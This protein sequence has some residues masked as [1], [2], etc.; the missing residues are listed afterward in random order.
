MA[1]KILGGI[2]IALSS[3]LLVAS[4]VGIAAAWYY[5]EPLTEE[6]VARLDK[7]NNELAQA[8]TAL[9]DAQGEL[10]RALRIVDSSEE[11]FENFGEQIAVAKGFLDTVTNVL[12]ETIKPNLGASRKKIDQAQQT[13]DDLRASIEALNRIPFISL[14]VPDDEILSS[15]V[16]IMDSL[17]GEITRV[18]GV[19]EQASTFLND[20]SYLLGGDLQETRDNIQKLQ[21]VVAEYESKIGAWRGQLAMLEAGLPGWID[22]ASLIL[23]IFLFWFGLSQFGLLLHGLALWRGRDPLLALRREPA[24]VAPVAPAATPQALEELDDAVDKLEEIAEDLDEKDK[25]EQD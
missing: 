21:R 15:F 3:I 6:A 17:E 11:A 13:L 9:Q 10:E 19:A 1:R 12:D 2:L 8:Q 25:R 20:S 14:E 24:P 7:A 18:E 16:E 5:N 22:R 23:T 4:L